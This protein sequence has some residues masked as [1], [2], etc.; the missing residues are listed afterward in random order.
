MHVIILQV[1]EVRGDDD[2]EVDDDQEP[3]LEK[4]RDVVNSGATYPDD[5]PTAVSTLNISFHQNKLYKL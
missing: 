1:V 5:E 4:L 2:D 3:Y